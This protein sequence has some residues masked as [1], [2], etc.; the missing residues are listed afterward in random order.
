MK[1]TAAT[2]ILAQRV[3]GGGMDLDQHFIL[4][5][6]RLI[7]LDNFQHIRGTA[8][9]VDECLHGLSP[10]IQWDGHHYNVI[11]D[12]PVLV[13]SGALCL[14]REGYYRLN[15]AGFLIS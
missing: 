9:F 11:R 8:F 1:K 4:F 5:W 3:D 2:R 13:S 12:G 15:F 14:D 10:R 7:A 6:G